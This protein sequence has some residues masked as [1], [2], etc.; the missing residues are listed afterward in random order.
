M[1]TRRKRSVA[2]AAARPPVNGALLWVTAGLTA[3]EAIVLALWSVL[4]RRLVPMEWRRAEAE[5]RLLPL[6]L[7]FLEGSVIDVGDLTVHEHRAL[8]GMLERYSRNLSGSTRQR[9]AALFEQQGRVA[10]EVAV[11][12]DRRPSRRIAAAYALGDMG[13]VGAVDG[14]RRALSDPD[15]RVCAASAHS[16]GRIGAVDTVE[17]IVRAVADGRLPRALAG[18]ALASVGAVA[19]AELERLMTDDDEHVRGLCAELVALVGIPSSAVRL[20]DL[21]HDSSAEVRATAARGLGRLGTAWAAAGLLLLLE[22]PDPVVRA[23]AAEAL[24]HVGGSEA[25]APLLAMC[26]SGDFEPAVAAAAAAARIDPSLVVDLAGEA[27]AGPH[28]REAGALLALGL[29]R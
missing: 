21:L 2:G 16:L 28:L 18:Q 15:P 10:L 14:L 20:S 9:V 22:D 29:L 4:S 8:A 13:S 19:R 7:A 12:S 5:R 24:G 23:A 26:A 17:S 3:G 1:R 27:G 11:L 6:A 25:V